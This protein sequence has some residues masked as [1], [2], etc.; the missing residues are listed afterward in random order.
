MQYDLI[1]AGAG[2]SG[3]SLAVELKNLNYQGKVLIIDKKKQFTNDRTW[4]GWGFNEYIPQ[5]L[6]KYQWKKLA[7]TTETN[8]HIHVCQ[9]SPY[10]MVDTI[11][12]YQ[13]CLN[14]LLTPQFDIKLNEEI[15][16]MGPPLVTVKQEYYA[17][18]YVD[19][20]TLPTQTHAIMK[21]HFL[22]LEC[23]FDRELE[24]PEQAIL[25]DFRVD[26]SQGLCFMY[27]LPFSS[28]SA[29][30][31]ITYFSE[32]ILDEESYLKQINDYCM[33][34][35]G[36]IKQI[37]H[38]EFG[39]IPME[40]SKMPP[41]SNN[42]IY[43]G[44]KGGCTRPGTGY[45]FQTILKH[46][47]ELAQAIIENKPWQ[48]C[49]FKKWQLLVDDIF[50]DALKCNPP[51]KTQIMLVNIFKKLSPVM[52]ERFMMNN[53]S[54]SDMIQIGACMPKKMLLKSSYNKLIKQQ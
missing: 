46:A 43:F 48:P 2:L 37:K 32:K 10:F 20:L 31:E 41:M 47:G 6:I 4:C 50:L 22:G 21:Q 24:N 16:S 11:G 34:Y 1:I 52:A 27:C 13:H 33:K 44:T 45:T 39:V 26:Q 17:Q 36:S 23:E 8:A 35:I 9:H 53:H 12:F 28:H 30:L 15:I 25:M 19:T 38:R 54:L 40:V 18:C 7:I 42:I 5:S 14:Q 3:L 49:Y 51:D 29:L